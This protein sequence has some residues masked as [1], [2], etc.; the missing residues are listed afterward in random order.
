MDEGGSVQAAA[1]KSGLVNQYFSKA[2]QGGE[3][4]FGDLMENTLRNW[5]HILSASM[6]NEAA[7]ATVKAAM[8]VGGA[9]PNLKV[10]LEWRLDDDGRNGKVYS[11]IMSIGYLGP[12]SKFLDVA[13]DFKNILQFGVTVSPAF[14]V[15]NLIRDSVQSA[16][17]SGIGLNIAKNVTEGIA[18]S[19][20]GN[21]DYISALAGGAIFNF[22]S[23]VEGDQAT[24]IKRLIEQGVKGENILDTIKPGDTMKKVE[25]F[26]DAL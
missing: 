24:M 7:N 2:L 9:F 16:A 22:G 20:R 15:R 12:K 5:S 13:R 1:T 26:E 14:K 19:K 6:K 11:A 23:Y 10:G 25:V 18:A 17:V 4:P 3:K 21:P 8:D